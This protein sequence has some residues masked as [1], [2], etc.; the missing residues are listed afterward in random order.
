MATKEYPLVTLY[1]CGPDYAGVPHVY[2][3]SWFEREKSF[4]LHAHH[5]NSGGG[6]GHV[7][8]I[9]KAVFPGKVS[10]Y[11]GYVA[12]T[13]EEAVALWRRSVC[14]E[15]LTLQTRADELLAL[16]E[17]ADR[18]GVPDAAKNPIK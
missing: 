15:R 17:T 5:G 6:F 3:G 10:V 13:R 12:R 4:N 16:I 8:V 9:Q 7:R 1:A 2:S 11:S 18:D 14:H